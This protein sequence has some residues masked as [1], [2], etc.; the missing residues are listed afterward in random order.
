MGDS[1]LML[2][3]FD[4]LIRYWGARVL[5]RDWGRN[6]CAFFE[7]SMYPR[8]PPAV[9]YAARTWPAAVCGEFDTSFS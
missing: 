2:L 1:D 9:A 4:F 6:E 8:K 3:D 7:A 5:K